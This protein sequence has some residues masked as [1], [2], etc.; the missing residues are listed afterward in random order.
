MGI[1]LSIM[2]KR[3]AEENAGIMENERLPHSAYS[4]ISEL[5]VAAVD[6]YTCAKSNQKGSVR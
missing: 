1:R 2:T 4:C 3:V 5:S 6:I